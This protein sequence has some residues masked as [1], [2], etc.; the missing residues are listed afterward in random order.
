L[1]SDKENKHSSPCESNIS[2]F[3]FWFV[4]ATIVDKANNAFYAHTHIF[5]LI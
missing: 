2:L 1:T 4:Y 5:L 3:Q